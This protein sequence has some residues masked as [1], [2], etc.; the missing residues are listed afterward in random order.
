MNSVYLNGSEDV[1]SA[2]SSMCQAALEM[3][4]AAT[5]IEDALHRN[6]MFMTDWLYQ[7]ENALAAIRAL[8][9]KP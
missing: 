6:Q 9:E 5:Q 7:F 2:A 3:K 1:R 4:Q 8:K